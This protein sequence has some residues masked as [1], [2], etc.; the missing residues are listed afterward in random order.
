MR[1]SIELEHE[2]TTPVL[3]EEE[4]RAPFDAERVAR[5]YP[6][7]IGDYPGRLGVKAGLLRVAYGGAAG[8]AK[9]DEGARTV[10]IEGRPR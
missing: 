5:C 6:E 7:P 4:W 10:M 9:K 1:R 3:G 8:F 2:L